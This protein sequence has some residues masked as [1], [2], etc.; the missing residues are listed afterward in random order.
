MKGEMGSLVTSS[1]IRSSRIMK[2]VALVS[3]STSRSEVPTSS[4]SAMFAACEVEP[5]ALGVEKS[6]VSLPPGRSPIMA[7]MS[8]PVTLRPSSALIFT[9]SERATTYSRPSPATWS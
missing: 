5:E 9:A 7:E 3:S 4:A 1:R 6:S 8:T 2:L